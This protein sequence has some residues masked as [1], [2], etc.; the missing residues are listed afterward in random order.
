MWIASGHVDAFVDPL[1]ECKQCHKRWRADQLIEA[2]AEENGISFLEA[3]ALKAVG[4]APQ[5]QYYCL[6]S[7]AGCYTDFHVDFGG[8]AVLYTGGVGC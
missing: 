1:T 7:A 2:F 8:T 4:Q 3:S 5:T 6:M